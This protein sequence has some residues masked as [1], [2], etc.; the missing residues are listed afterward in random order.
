MK[1]LIIYY[2]GRFT[3]NFF[4][5]N[6]FIE[7]NTYRNKTHCLESYKIQCILRILYMYFFIFHHDICLRIFFY[8]KYFYWF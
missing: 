8:Q 3:C 7:T 2:G 1:I 4:S 5:K 6:N